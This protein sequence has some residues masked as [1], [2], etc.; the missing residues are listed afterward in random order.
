MTNTIVKNVVGGSTNQV[1]NQ[2]MTVTA[3]E[4]ELRNRARTVEATS[5][6][7][8]MN[9]MGKWK[10]NSFFS[11]AISELEIIK[12]QELKKLGIIVNTLSDVSGYGTDEISGRSRK[13]EVV[14]VRQLYCY[15]AEK[16]DNSLTE[17]GS[18]VN[19]DHSTVIYSNNLITS[20]LNNNH[21]DTKSIYIK[22]IFAKYDKAISGN[23]E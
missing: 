9:L 10:R 20:I 19:L 5:F 17:I 7:R 13:L 15:L 21:W 4:P 12:K 22:K 14:S 1:M 8:A 2:I 11:R 18:V 3:K 23:N 6:L 16:T